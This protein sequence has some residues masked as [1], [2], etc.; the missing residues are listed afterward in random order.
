MIDWIISGDNNFAFSLKIV[1]S[2]LKMNFKN[3]SIIVYS[4]MITAIQWQSNAIFGIFEF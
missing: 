4:F 3:C 2:I 1:Q